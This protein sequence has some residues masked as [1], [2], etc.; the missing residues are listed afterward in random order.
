MT[1]RECAREALCILWGLSK[2]VCG[3]LAAGFG[4]IG[5]CGV[6]DGAIAVLV[7]PVMLAIILCG[8]L[9]VGSTIRRETIIEEDEQ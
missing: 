2:I 6:Y 7:L 4:V 1:A 3:F 5:L 9:T 8:F